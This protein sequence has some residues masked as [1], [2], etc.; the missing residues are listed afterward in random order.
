MEI[1]KIYKQVLV[2][3]LKRPENWVIFK[4]SIGL[5]LYYRINCFDD[6]ESYFKI[7]VS[8]DNYDKYTIYVCNDVTVNLI[9]NVMNILSNTLFH[10][11]IKIFEFKIVSLINKLRKYHK[12]KK[13]REEREQNI[14]LK[15]SLLPNSVL[16]SLKINKIK[17]SL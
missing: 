10:F 3:K 4:E 12:N 15:E 7:T 9:P 17:K 1:D 2:E 13:K 8:N 11:K 5:T 16:R 6:N 14:K